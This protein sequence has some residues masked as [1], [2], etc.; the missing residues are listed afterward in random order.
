M[1]RQLNR[2]G[3]PEGRII[4]LDLARFL[5][6]IGMMALHVLVGPQAEV[7]EVITT[8]FPSTLF[9][10]LGGV[11]IVISTRRYRAV[12][13]PRAATFSV[14][15]RGAAIA[16]LGVFLIAAPR[17]V[18]VVLLYYGIAL[19]ITALFLHA[20]SAVLICSI[21]VLALGVPQ[22]SA[23]VAH[24]DQTAGPAVGAFSYI[25][26]VGPYPVATW[27]TYML[28]GMLVGRVLTTK[29]R[30]RGS[31]VLVA[32]GASMFLV[33]TIADL[34]SR[35]AVIASL[36]ASGMSQNEAE[37]AATSA[38]NGSPIDTGWV[39]VLN[40]VPHSGTTADVLRTAGAA[41]LVIAIM[42][43]VT[44]SITAVI[45][46]L[47]RP[48]VAAGAAPLT[49]YT[50]HVLVTSVTTIESRYTTFSD[51]A[52]WQLGLVA[53]GLH[54]AGA[55]AVGAVLV[56]LHR[57]GPLERLVSTVANAGARLAGTR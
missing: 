29:T 22:L 39:A 18:I 8:G 6:I 9:A 17:F 45:P 36:R 32:A 54:V 47:L 35:P 14:L 21:V 2:S 50:L 49:I 12:G 57:K 16:V 10:V 26:L 48:P 42:L 34:L 55:V 43:L 11:S 24:P 51:P 28:I 46:A 38:R 25:F 56:A 37:L 3:Y 19:M 15:A 4:A 44:T 23:W 52:W 31:S 1:P 30:S 41:L 40:G 27:M 13:R 53:L 20:R 33:G 5:A 7:I